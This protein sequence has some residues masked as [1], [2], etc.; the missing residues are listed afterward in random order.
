[1]LSG[2][3]HVYETAFVAMTL[4][5]GAL[6]LRLASRRRPG[7]LRAAR[8]LW[9]AGLVVLIDHVGTAFAVFHHYSH[10][11]AFRHTAE[12]TAEVV[13]WEWGVGLY[14]NYLFLLVWIVDVIWWWCAAE[15]YERRPRP[16]AW[17]VHGFLAFMA[18]NAT[19][20]FGHGVVQI[21][22]AVATLVLLG[23]WLLH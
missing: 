1:M 23:A 5:A 14:F 9:T 13:G 8:L 20:V 10:D 21:A 3:L 22:G 16:I 11:A 4:Y 18:F 17:F 6:A 19:V 7:W 12:R 2:V 15:S